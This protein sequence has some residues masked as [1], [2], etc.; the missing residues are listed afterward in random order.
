MINCSWITHTTHPT[1]SFPLT[2]SAVK[3]ICLSGVYFQSL[4]LSVVA[5]S[6][7]PYTHAKWGVQHLS[8]GMLLLPIEPLYDDAWSFPHSVSDIVI[9]PPTVH[10]PS[11][12]LCNCMPVSLIIH[13]PLYLALLTE[14]HPSL[15]LG[16]TGGCSLPNRR[17]EIIS[18][19]VAWWSAV[20]SMM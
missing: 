18:T 1:P 4:P 19:G 11:S 14:P 2:F 16:S 8:W 17:Q 12:W 5:F 20:F 6:M 3:N 10:L 13:L 9:Q 7:Q 15:C